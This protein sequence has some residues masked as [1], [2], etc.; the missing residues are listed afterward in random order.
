MRERNKNKTVVNW[1]FTTKDA[2]IKLKRFYLSFFTK[3]IL[4]GQGIRRKTTAKL[5][6]RPRL[7]R[8][9][10]GLKVRCSTN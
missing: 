1:Q 4:V 5:V 2:R 3:L 7:E 10:N 9:T 8:G 6:G